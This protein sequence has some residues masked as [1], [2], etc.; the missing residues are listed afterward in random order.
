MLSNYTVSH[1]ERQYSAELFLVL[2]HS[3][4]HGRLHL[5]VTEQ[6]MGT[7]ITKMD[8][9]SGILLLLTSLTV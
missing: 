6:R 1:Q 7:T 3:L 5:H 2:G 4:T 9:I 8:T